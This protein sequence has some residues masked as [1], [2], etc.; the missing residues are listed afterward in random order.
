MEI[1]LTKRRTSENT[2]KEEKF[3]KAEMRKSSI[4]T[5]LEG[6]CDVKSL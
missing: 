6:I 3:P 4:H 1:K 2:N 5:L